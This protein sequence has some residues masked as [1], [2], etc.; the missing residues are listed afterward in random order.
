MKLEPEEREPCGVSGLTAL[1]P[2]RGDTLDLSDCLVAR[3]RPFRLVIWEPLLTKAPAPPKARP[4]CCYIRTV[5]FYHFPYVLELRQPR[6]RDWEGRLHAGARGYQ[7]WDQIETRLT[8]DDVVRFED[9]DFVV[10]GG[11]VVWKRRRWWMVR[12]ARRRAAK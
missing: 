1:N 9:E 12:H 10:G 8:W 4:W 3:P 5:I 2:F 11:T 6:W 7:E